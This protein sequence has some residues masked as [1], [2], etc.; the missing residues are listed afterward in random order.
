LR[1]LKYAPGGDT[2]VKEQ[3]AVIAAM[4]G[5]DLEKSN[6]IIVGIMSA[7]APNPFPLLKAGEGVVYQPVP[8]ACPL[9]LPSTYEKKKVFLTT[10][11]IPDE[12]IWANGLFQ[13]VYVIT[14]CL[15][16]WVVNLGC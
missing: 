15:K 4:R 8:H 2:A 11:R 12:H 16:R 7:P 5:V 1:R 13:N 10:V 9:T 6:L 3:R 14:K